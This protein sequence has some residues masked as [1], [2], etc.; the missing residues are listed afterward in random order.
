MTNAHCIDTPR[1]TRRRARFA[2]LALITA[3]LETRRQRRA[4]T[5]LD[6][7]LLDD[8]GLSPGTAWSE[9]KRPFWELPDRH[10]W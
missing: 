9:A 7:H 6:D 1:A 4:L 8:I 3:A 5:L 10:H 2:P